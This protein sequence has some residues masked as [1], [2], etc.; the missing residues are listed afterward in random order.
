M[1]KRYTTHNGGRTYGYQENDRYV[2]PNAPLR[3]EI[4]NRIRGG[5]AIGTDYVVTRNGTIIHRC[6]TRELAEAF[7]SDHARV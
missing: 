3:I 1:A 5:R 7:V 4:A 2:S 6:E